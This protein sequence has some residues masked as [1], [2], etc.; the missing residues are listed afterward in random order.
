MEKLR[1]NRFQKV[2][3]I[4]GLKSTLGGTPSE[5]SRDYNGL[6][7]GWFNNHMT[8]VLMAL[9]SPRL[10]TSE[11]AFRIRF[12][13]EDIEHHF[14]DSHAPKSTRDSFRYLKRYFRIY[15]GVTENHCRRAIEMVGGIY[16][17]LGLEFG[18]QPE[19]DELPFFKKQQAEIRKEISISGANL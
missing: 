11:T 7:R 5:R 17:V 15:P 9:Q 3:K 10:R 13:L 16:Q 8:I 1:N 19:M 14:V 2:E 18:F 4:E 6:F 12:F